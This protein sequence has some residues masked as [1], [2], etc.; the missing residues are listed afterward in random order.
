MS[1]HK[2]RTAEQRQSDHLRISEM[3]VQG[4]SQKEIAQELGLSKYTVCRDIKRIEKLRLKLMCKNLDAVRAREIAKL[5]LMEKEAWAAWNKSKQPR[6]SKSV[7]KGTM[8]NKAQVKIEERVGDK[9]FM[10]IILECQAR[11]A[12]LQGLDAPARVDLTSD[13]QPIAIAVTK[14]DIDEL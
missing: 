13:G 12:K 8:L 10:D 14:M 1:E 7:T 6:T 2:Q 5:D 4:L 9:G 3:L 11:R